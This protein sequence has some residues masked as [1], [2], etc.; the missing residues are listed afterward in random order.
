MLKEPTAAIN[1][2]V[3]VQI[4]TQH[5]PA[6]FDIIP[7]EDLKKPFPKPKNQILFTHVRGEIPPHVVP[8]IDLE[9]LDPWKIVFA[10]DLHSHSNCQR[11]IV[12]PG[13]PVTTSFHRSKVNTGF[14]LLE[15]DNL[16]WEFVPLNLPQ[17]LKETV[18]CAEDM[19]KT[20]FH[21]T[22][23]ELESEAGQVLDKDNELLDKVIY[24]KEFKP[25]L[26]LTSTNSIVQELDI[27]LKDIQ[28]IKDTKEYIKLYNDYITQT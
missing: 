27:Y 10:G 9:L 12:Y 22:I 2:K 24:D 3:I 11:N 7:Y 4:G 23:Y 16:S 17:L 20:E 1:N 5:Y 15:T 6:G 21:H 19:V 8:E 18:T 13:S 14:I 25:S 26:D 28:K